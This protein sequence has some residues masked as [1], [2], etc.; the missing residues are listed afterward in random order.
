MK[1]ITDFSFR[2]IVGK[3]VLISDERK[4]IDRDLG[5]EEYVAYC[6]ID[7]DRGISFK[8]YAGIKDGNID[9]IYYD[10]PYSTKSI[11][12]RYSAVGKLEVYNSVTADMEKQAS[13]IES[14]YTPEW[15]VKTGI[16]DD[17]D[18]DPFRD[19]VYPDDLL[20]PVHTLK[21]GKQ[22]REDLWVRPTRIYEHR[23]VGKTIESGKVISCGE[24]LAILKSGEEKCPVFGVTAEW[25]QY[26]NQINECDS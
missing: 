9:F 11:T 6:Y 22:I 17:L 26:Y 21:N 20:I 8:V 13:E 24:E 19:K 16:R 4:M 2:D 23:L 7:V 25:L 14:I 3:Y 15:I 18:F 10:N 5:Y 1:K 12:L